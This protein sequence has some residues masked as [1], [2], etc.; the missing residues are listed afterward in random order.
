MLHSFKLWLV[1]NVLRRGVLASALLAAAGVEKYGLEEEAYGLFRRRG[2]HLLREHYYRPIPDDADL[3]ED[4][5]GRRTEL[6]GLDMN[7]AAA[8]DLLDNVFPLYAREFRE[9]FPLR[10]PEGGDDT[11]FHL[12]NGAFMAVD[13]HAY[14]ALIRH[15]KPSR[16]VEVGAGRS[17]LLSAACVREMGGEGAHLTAVDPYPP[18]FLK[19]GLTGLAR[20]VESKVQDVDLSLFTSLAAGDILF[21]DS[22]HVLRA[23]G[24]VEFEFC[25][26]LPRLAPGVFVHVHDISLP[27]AYPRVY[28]DR[29]RYYW[30]EQ[31]VLQTFL[32]FN[33]RFEVVWPGNYMMLK[34]PERV[35]AVFPEVRVMRESFPE[36]EPSS[37]WMRVRE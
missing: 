11:Q 29:H 19:R 5:W 10:A 17:T 4:Y 27:K 6:V 7:D 28:F 36:S 34:Y 31:Q 33:H 30:N 26:I 37:F 20:L 2:F 15:F 14:Y 21:I 24:D 8:L 9:R 1:R 13:A 23:G 25:E 18:E 22:T 12:I 32:A 3:N 16:I 35:A